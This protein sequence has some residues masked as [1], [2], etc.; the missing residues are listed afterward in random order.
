MTGLAAHHSVMTVMRVFRQEVSSSS[1][2]LRADVAVQA[3]III[4][5]HLKKIA[6]FING[7]IAK[8]EIKTTPDFS[9]NGVIMAIFAAHI[10]LLVEIIQVGAG[11]L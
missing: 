1:H 8:N 10:C 9:R 4:I 5:C 6:V 11:Q 7:V 3:H 2:K